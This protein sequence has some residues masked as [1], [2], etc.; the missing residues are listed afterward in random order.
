MESVLRSD[1]NALDELEVL[2]ER[3]EESCETVFIISQNAEDLVLQ[4]PEISQ[5]VED[6]SRLSRYLPML[7]SH[8]EI[9]ADEQRC[10]LQT[11]KGS[12]YSC[13]KMRS[14]KKGRPKYLI[15]LEQIEFLKEQ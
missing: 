4:N 5:F 9:L 8:I 15:S 10:R 6:M 7:R 2:E 13:Q 12:S 14:G 11:Q 1:E 3:L